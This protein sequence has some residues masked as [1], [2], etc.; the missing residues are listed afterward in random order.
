M[1]RGEF[2]RFEV[3]EEKGVREEE[4][5]NLIGMMEEKRMRNLKM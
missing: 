3:E 4:G 2:G 5:T 1:G